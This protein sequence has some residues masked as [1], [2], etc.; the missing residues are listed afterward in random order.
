MAMRHL[1][2]HFN[3]LQLDYVDLLPTATSAA[4]PEVH[5][6]LLTTATSAA[7]PQV[8][9]DVLTLDQACTTLCMPILEKLVCSAG[10][11]GNQPYIVKVHS[12]NDK[13]RKMIN[14]TTMVRGTEV[15]NAYRIT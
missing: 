12:R 3:S 5:V 15:D 1:N 10:N 13:L 7:P 9:V 2:C 4:P 6:D 8:H 14:K 11:Y